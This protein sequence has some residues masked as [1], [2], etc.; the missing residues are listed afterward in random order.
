MAKRL[1]TYSSIAIASVLTC[2]GAW[3]LGFGPVRAT[4]YL[5][6]PLDVSIPLHLQAGETIADS[7][8]SATVSSG[9]VLLPAGT[10]TASL[11]QSPGGVDP[12]VRVRTTGRIDEPFVSVTVQLGCDVRLSRQFTIFADP[13]P[14]TP[15]I[16]SGSRIAAPSA[17]TETRTV[18]AAAPAGVMAGNVAAPPASSRRASSGA[19]RREAK[20]P[21][22]R[23]VTAVNRERASAVPTLASDSASKTESADATRVSS[24]LVVKSESVARLRLDAPG[25][26]AITDSALAQ[27]MKKREE[28]ALATAKIAVDV[29]EAANNSAAQRVAAIEASLANLRKENA[30]QRASMDR[31]RSQISDGGMADGLLPWLAG[32]CIALA[33]LAG[34][35]FVRM[36]KL[37][38]VRAQTWLDERG[39]ITRQSEFD[40]VGPVAD[41]TFVTAQAPEAA[42][43]VAANTAGPRTEP[44][45]LQPLPPLMPASRFAETQPSSA[46][47]LDQTTPAHDITI[48][49]L[50]DVE[51]QAEF[52]IVLGQDDAAIDLLTSHV[53]A[54]GGA[55]PMPYLKLL[56][57]YRRIG[58]QTS[59][60]R[61]RKRFNARFNGV[62]PEWS[63]DP[64]GGRSLDE[65]PEVIHR[66]QKAWPRPLDAMADLQTLMFRNDSNLLFELPAYRD[67]MLLF[68]LAR[69]MHDAS[70]DDQMPV[71]VLLPLSVQAGNALPDL[72]DL[73]DMPAP[74]IETS[75]DDDLGLSFAFEETGS[76][77]LPAGRQTR[78]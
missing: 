30:E 7:C 50:L 66:V 48:E 34:F 77:A 5:G 73:P 45:T 46:F 42:Q 47:E 25:V 52:F 62:A 68:T 18:Q 67:I 38:A 19:V 13:P 61:T 17:G 69:D 2:Q 36:R 54:S 21:V 59:Y 63:A 71:D 8:V 20:A 15:V 1:L 56:E 74:G 78:H 40:T 76:G 75:A 9:D 4:A 29:A 60:E 58:D 72:T 11:V 70:A 14:V 12:R 31:M 65:Y 55:S 35:F 32:A 33:G 41:S 26:I 16:D 51:Q 37:D 44:D 64:N 6:Y 49:E 57:I 43:A 23:S 10:V 24:G 3:S 27:V 22:A 53:M 39:P 28:E